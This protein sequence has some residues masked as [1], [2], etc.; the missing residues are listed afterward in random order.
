M[1]IRAILPSTLAAACF[2]LAACGSGEEGGANLSALATGQ[3]AAFEVTEGGSLP[4]LTV[5]DREGKARA[6]EDDLAEVTLVNLWA[7]WCP[8]CIVEMPSLEALQE[9]Y[10]PARFRVVPVSLDQTAGKAQDF[11][12]REGLEALPFRHDPDFVSAGAFAAPGLPISVLYDSEG[13]EIGRLSG[14]AEWDSPEARA[15]IDA[16]LA[17]EGGESES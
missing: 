7:T 9:S 14:P 11:Y 3:M 2:I 10:D 16:A 15:L 5:Y 17:T 1:T 4:E 12:D 8:P 13:N 6:L